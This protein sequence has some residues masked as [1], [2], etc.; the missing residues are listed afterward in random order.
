[1]IFIEL[2]YNI[3]GKKGVKMISVGDIIKTFS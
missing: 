1:M 2:L 3:N